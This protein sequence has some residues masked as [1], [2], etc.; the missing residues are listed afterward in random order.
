M[1]KKK[2]IQTYIIGYGIDSEFK[3]QKKNEKGMCLQK[4][5]A[6]GKYQQ[7]DEIFFSSKNFHW[8]KREN[9]YIVVDKDDNLIFHFH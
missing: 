1:R 8:E 6:I 9:N 7:H 3:I 5:F 4:E 2:S